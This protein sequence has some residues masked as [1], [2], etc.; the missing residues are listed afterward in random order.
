M[1]TA[2]PLTGLPQGESSRELAR[3]WRTLTRA[4][5]VVAVLTSPALFERVP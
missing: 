5:T 4:A 3:G 2:E 1:A